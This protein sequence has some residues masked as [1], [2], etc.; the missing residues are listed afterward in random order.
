LPPPQ[1]KTTTQNNTT[2][3]KPSLP[4]HDVCRRIE[5]STTQDP[6]QKPPHPH[7][8][9]ASPAAAASQKPKIQDKNPSTVMSSSTSSATVL[10]AALGSPPSQPLTRENALIWKALV[11]PALRGARVL[12][13]VEGNEEAPEKILE[14]E[15]INK[16]KVTIENPEYAAWISCDQ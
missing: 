2:K 14:T 5:T 4:P 12:D 13:L 6:R 15:D 11:I 3:T 7:R 10:A 8:I 1:A 16:K 9:P